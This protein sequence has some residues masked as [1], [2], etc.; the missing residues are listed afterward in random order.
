[1]KYFI[2]FLFLPFLLFGFGCSDDLPEN[3]QIDYEEDVKPLI[4][5]N[6][7]HKVR[8]SCNMI[9]SE[10]H[11]L[12]YIGSIWTEQQIQ[13]NCENVGIF[14]LNTCPY[15]EN[16]GCLSGRDTMVEAVIWSYPYG[17][18]PITGEELKYESMACDALAAAEWVTPDGL[19]LEP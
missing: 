10:S 5:E 16:G 7:A 3:Q 18:Q 14:S 1:M 19:F 2:P 4:E 17:G 6:T 13:L 8:G 15:S 12:D 11:C 9:D